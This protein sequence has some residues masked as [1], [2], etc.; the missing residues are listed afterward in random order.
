VRDERF[1]KRTAKVLIAN[2]SSS[3]RSMFQNVL[4]GLGFSVEGCDAPKDVLGRLE[5]EEFDWI[6]L[7]VA[8]DELING[9][10]VLDALSHVRERVRVRVSFIVEEDEKEQLLLAYELGLMNWFSAGAS[11]DDV[12]DEFESFLH[13]LEKL[14]FDPVLLAAS[15][16]RNLLLESSKHAEAA[17]F[18]EKLYEIYSA[19]E[20]VLLWLAEAYLAAGIGDC[21]RTL[22]AQLK[23]LNVGG[24]KELSAKYLGDSEELNPDLG[25]EKVVVVDPDEDIHKSLSDLL[26][27]CGVQLKH[28]R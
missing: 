10:H 4:R 18:L 26:T 3:M 6:I 9:F 24:W 27:R 25:I 22:L 7:P 15:S 16:L 13:N 8:K 28:A 17:F 11:K 23:A 19:D 1:E 2:K 14:N 5:V 21:G 12:A 20:S